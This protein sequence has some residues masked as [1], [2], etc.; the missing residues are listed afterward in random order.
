MRWNLNDNSTT[1]NPVWGLGASITGYGDRKNFTQLFAAKDIIM[2]R[3]QTLSL[4][5]SNSRPLLT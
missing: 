5:S 4:L 1:V 3:D 2:V